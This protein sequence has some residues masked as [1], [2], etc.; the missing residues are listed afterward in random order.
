MLLGNDTPEEQADAI[1]ESVDEIN[2]ARKRVARRVDAIREEEGDY[3]VPRGWD[4]EEGV[5]DEEEE[6]RED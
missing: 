1:G 3:E 4:V 2:N 6:E 5:A